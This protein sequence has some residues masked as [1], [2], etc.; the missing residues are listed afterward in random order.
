VLAIGKAASA[1]AQAALAGLPRPHSAAI[2][3][4]PHGMQLDDLDRVPR[5]RVMHAAHPVPDSAS[6]AAADQV[7]GVLANAAVD[8]VVI[9]L[10]S[11]GASSLCVAPVRSITVDDYAAVVRALLLA[12][13]DIREL[14]TVRAHID[15]LKGGGMAR[16]AA[17]ARVLGLIVSDVVDN[18]LDVIASGPLSP[19]LTSRADAVRV[20]ERYRAWNACAASIRRALTVDDDPPVNDF[21]HVQLCVI[22]DNRTAVSAAADAARRLGY[23][24]RVAAQPITGIA[25][26]AGARL[27]RAAIDVAATLRPGDRPVCMLWG[28]ETTVAVQGGGTGGRNQELVLA[29]AIALR[30]AA[31]ITIASFGTDGVDG[32][33]D[34]A[35][36][37]ADSRTVARGARAG[38]DAPLSLD[39]NDSFTYF[40]TAGGQIRTGPTGTN[41]SDVQVALV[42]APLVG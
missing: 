23:E 4:V 39:D 19:P 11:G 33:T 13:A 37:V 36:A 5:N 32:P 12:G 28:G 18:P 27:A 31:G 29:A 30:Y 17:P 7:I 10:I 26:D 16:I 42:D 24:V 25:R 9:A 1:M 3:I 15:R 2:V 8:D 14:N 40:A 41:V 34:A 6:A 21:D 22:A 35:G 20:L 38:I